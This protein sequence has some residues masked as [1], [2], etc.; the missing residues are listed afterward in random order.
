MSIEKA[1]YQAPV[2]LDSLA[3]EEEPIEIE[4]MALEVEDLS[5]EEKDNLEEGFDDNLA[6]YIPEKELL[7]IAGDLI[8]DF[9]ED[10]SSRKDW[11]QTY[12]DGLELLGMK[13]E[14]RTEP[15]EGACGVYHPLLSEALVKFQ[16]ETIME[17]FPAQG[18]VKTLIIGKETPEKK[19]AAIRVQD[20]MNYQL[21]D[22]MSEYRP[23]HER[24]IWGLG[25]SGNAFKK[26]YFD[27]AL[28][29]QVS[30]FIPAEDIVVPYGASS[31]QSAPRVTHV[32][33]KTENEIKRLQHAGFYRDIELEEPDGALDEVEKK[34]AEKMGFRATSDDRYKL[35]EMHVDLDLSGYED[36]EDGE[37]TGIALPYVV[38]IEKG[39][40]TILSIRRNWRPEDETKQKRNHFVH[41]GYVPG[42]GFY[43]FGL[44]HLVGAFA[45]SGTSLIR[46]L[47]DA[48]TLSNLPG[49]FKTRGLRVKG[50]DTPIAPGEFRDVD[51]PS[52]A[53]KDN[54]MTLPYKEP[55]QVLYSLLGTIVEEGRRF[56]SAGDMKISDMSGQAPVGTTLAILERTL[57]V[58][59]AV[60]SRIHYSMKQELKLLK[61]IIADYTPDDYNYEPVEG[62]RKAKK[63]DYD[64]VD[65]IPVSDPNA[66]TMAQKIVQYQ[67]VL[68]LAQ[69]APQIY[70]L[71]Q[72]HR[73]MLDVL[74]IRNAQKLIPLDDDQ[75]PIDPIRENMNVLIG[76]P[77]KAFIRQDQD[78]HLTAHLAFLQDPQTAAII[79]QNPM[80]QQITAALQAHMAE[81]YGFKY[82]QQIEQQLGAPIPY[83]ENEDDE[84]MSEEYEVQ[85]SRMVAQ[86]A[87]QLT[88]QNQA[89]AAQQEAQ[90]KAEDPII[91]MQ[92][93]ELAIKAQE[94]QRKA[95]RDQAD[96][97]LENRRLDIEEQR[98]MGQLEIEGTRLG[99]SI[100][101]D[102]TALDR[103]SEFE[104]TK[105]GVDMAHKKQQV[106]VQ[107]G[108]VAAQLIAAEINANSNAKKGNNKK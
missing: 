53:I 35:L 4:I 5:T 65:V 81:H 89:A 75:K 7:Q 49:G 13:I 76:K 30:M 18:P 47:V 103:K 98:T 58:M 8:G 29:R 16:A 43:C 62:S 97:T 17:T 71:P 104:G 40:M 1:L 84:P 25:L 59:S 67:A 87:Q 61:S 31:L 32:M 33:R 86:A 19:D 85:L 69:G 102:K 60:Q 96:I 78:A 70:N 20:D 51:V 57:K 37:P 105:L 64:L 27:P 28:N 82:R 95:Q 79:G 48:G 77:L 42:F 26:V 74:G 22:V 107:K 39:T 21:T 50:D 99:V 38:T 106:D 88:T 56:A 23:E 94:Q 2:G 24:M 52:G 3:V 80:A 101:K 83:S 63:S 72:L 100:E 15:W 66:A 12:V 93:Q 46:Q 6:E 36:E 45:K 11:I 44:I 92:Q 108:Q 73:Q 14:E 90:Q 54:L 41:Y 68:Q 10:I 9:E 34:I 55:S 91:Q